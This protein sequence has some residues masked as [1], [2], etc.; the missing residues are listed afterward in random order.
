MAMTKREEMPSDAAVKAAEFVRR[1]RLNVDR[2][3]A[4]IE[5]GV[6]FHLVQRAIWDAVVAS[7]REVDQMV[8]ATLRADLAASR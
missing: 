1:L 7:G 8:L 6:D 5:G 3:D 4:G 2:L